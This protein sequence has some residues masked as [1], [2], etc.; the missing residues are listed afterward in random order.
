MKNDSQMTDSV[1]IATQ[2]QRIHNAPDSQTK[3]V[4][5]A[6]HTPW[7]SMMADTRSMAD[8]GT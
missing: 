8:I 4:L 1:R 2:K 3:E 7:F 5:H 6:R